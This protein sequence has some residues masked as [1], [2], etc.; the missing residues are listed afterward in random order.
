MFLSLVIHLISGKYNLVKND[1]EKNIKPIFGNITEILFIY[2][3]F[4]LIFCSFDYKHWNGIEKKNDDTFKKKF[5]NRLYFTS[6]TYSTA[7]YGDVSPKSNKCKIAVMVLQLMIL[8][9]TV[10][11]VLKKEDNYNL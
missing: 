6:T 3:I 1:F 7:G 5:F 2:L 10:G 9:E 11:V 8:I 4:T